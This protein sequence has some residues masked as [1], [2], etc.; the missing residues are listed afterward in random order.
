ML[1]DWEKH[2]D[3]NYGFS[4]ELPVFD[5]TGYKDMEDFDY[6]NRDVIY[7]ML[8]ACIELGIENQFHEVPCMIIDEIIFIIK[9]K[10]YL[11][12]IKVCLRYFENQEEFEKCGRLVTLRKKFE[13]YGING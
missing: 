7:N 1:V 5:S 12:K 13:E 11:N 8:L 9:Q 10:D 6:Q 2:I 4:L 3:A